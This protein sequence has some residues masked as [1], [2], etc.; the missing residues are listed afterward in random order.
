MTSLSQDVSC[1]PQSSELRDPKRA[2]TGRTM[3][4]S[5]REALYLTLGSRGG[6]HRSSPVQILQ[7]AN[8]H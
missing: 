2:F 3:D 4:E 1:H 8:S 7:L 6:M 5:N